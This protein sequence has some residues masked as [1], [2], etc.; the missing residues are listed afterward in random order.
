[1]ITSTE[2]LSPNLL[3]YLTKMNFFLM[4]NLEQ[5]HIVQ[6]SEEKRVLE[7]SFAVETAIVLV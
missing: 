6:I 1:M 7:F 4:K 5:Y 3:D 2:I